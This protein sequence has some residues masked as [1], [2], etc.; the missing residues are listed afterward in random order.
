MAKL[1]ATVRATE[2]NTGK[3]SETTLN[4]EVIVPTKRGDKFEAPENI[5]SYAAGFVFKEKLESGEI[6]LVNE[7]GG[8]CYL[9]NDYQIE[10]MWLQ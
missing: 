9:E 4:Y 3:L 10:K 5:D 6:I 8:W 1:M 2:G 7:N